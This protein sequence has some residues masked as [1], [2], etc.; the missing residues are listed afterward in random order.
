MYRASNLSYSKLFSTKFNRIWDTFIKTRYYFSIFT[1]KYDE[2]CIKIHIKYRLKSIVIHIVLLIRN[3]I[4]PQFYSQLMLL[5]DTFTVIWFMGRM[6]TSIDLYYCLLCKIYVHVCFYFWYLLVLVFPI[7]G[8]L[9]YNLCFCISL[10][11]LYFLLSFRFSTEVHV[12][13]LVYYYI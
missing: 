5:A 2:I 13:F 10:N 4:H 8:H 7:L 11:F 6:N 3:D 9:L 1:L 12:S